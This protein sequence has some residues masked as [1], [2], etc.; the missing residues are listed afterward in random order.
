VTSPVSAVAQRTK[1]DKSGRSL[2]GQR[3]HVVFRRSRHIRPIG[4]ISLIVKKGRYVTDGTYVVTTSPNQ[5]SN[6]LRHHRL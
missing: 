1:V 3:S 5:L 6:Q 4:L 2:G